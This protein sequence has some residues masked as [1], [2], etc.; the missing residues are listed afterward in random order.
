TEDDHRL[1]ALY[2]AFEDRFRGARA[3]IRERQRAHLPVMRAAGAGT[4]ARPIVDVGA[5]RGEWLELLRDEGLVALGVD[6]NARMAALCREMG[7]DCAADDAI[8]YLRRLPD[9]SVG[10]VT[11]F[12]IIE[13][14]P[15]RVFVALLDESLRVLAPGGVVLFETPNPANVLVGSRYFYLDPTHRNPMPAEMTAMIA[16]ARGFVGVRIHELHPSQAR[17]TARD[18]VLAAQLDALFHG[19]Q[20]YALIAGKA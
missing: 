11:G 9:A 18:E 13:H 2:V 17:F 7:L 8:E 14:L 3:D 4:A 1:D 6:L 10:A 20:D 15:F 12:H 5:G 19:P 16:E